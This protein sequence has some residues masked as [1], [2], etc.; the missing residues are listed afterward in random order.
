MVKPAMSSNQK[1]NEAR[2][3]SKKMAS[4]AA[5]TTATTPSSQLDGEPGTGGRPGSSQTTIA[6][7]GS[8]STTLTI[9]SPRLLA[10][11]STCGE[12]GRSSDRFRSPLRIAAARKGADQEAVAIA[13][14]LTDRK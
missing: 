13:T 9:F 6:I 2:A 5:R 4:R 3:M 7:T 11:R 12:I 14:T 1:A 8:S 10:T